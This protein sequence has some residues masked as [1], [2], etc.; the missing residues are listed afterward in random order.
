MKTNVK[1]LVCTA[2]MLL[3]YYGFSQILSYTQATS[4]DI[5]GIF[6]GGKYTKIQVEAKWGSP[7]QYGS[8]TSENGLNEF[9]NYTINQINNQ[10]L[11]AENGIF[12]TFNIRTSSFAVYT[13]F[14]GGI[15]VGDNISRI[16]AI[17]LGTPILQSNGTYHLR[18]NN[19]TD[20]L[21]FS[22]SNGIITQISFMT[23]V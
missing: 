2:L 6:I 3:P 4:M 13:A 17:G 1:S 19:S 20:P 12:H 7:T 16:Q 8:N 9:Y 5:N 10:F 22:H 11:F 23:S 18:R 21:V 14:S 15:K